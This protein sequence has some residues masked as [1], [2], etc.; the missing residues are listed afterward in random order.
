[1]NRVMFILKLFAREPLWYQVLI[2]AALL[3]SIL[4]SSSFFAEGYYPSLSK[5]A[6]AVFFVAVGFKL[7]QNR[8]VAGVFLV[9][10]VLCL[11]LSWQS[12][13]EVM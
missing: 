4:F 11:Y 2:V 7:R 6:A 9:V 8:T 12:Y 13:V 3:V 10:T 1:M 5:L